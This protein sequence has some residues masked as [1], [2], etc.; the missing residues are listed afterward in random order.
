METTDVF[1]VPMDEYQARCNNLPTFD[2]Y[3]KTSL[4]KRLKVEKM[5]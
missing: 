1:E 2:V 3:L 5:M 4:L